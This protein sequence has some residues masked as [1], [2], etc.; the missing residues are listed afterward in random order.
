EEVIDGDEA[1]NKSNDD[2]GWIDEIEELMEGEKL[3]IKKSIHPIKVALVKFHKLTF[4]MINLT[5]II[6]PL[7]EMQESV[8]NLPRDIATHWNSTYDTLEY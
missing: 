7:Q 2:E 6:L 5:T 8:T 3:V 4:K 1:G